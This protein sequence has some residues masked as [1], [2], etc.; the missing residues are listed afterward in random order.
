MIWALKKIQEDNRKF[1][2]YGRLL[3][4][5]F[6]QGVLLTALKNSGVV[7]DVHLGTMIGK[8]INGFTLRSMGIVKNVD[9]LEYDLK[10]S[11]IVPDLMVDFPPISIED[12][13]E[14]LAAYVTTHYEKT[15]EII[16]L[17]SIPETQVGVP[18]RVASKKRKSKKAFLDYS[19]STSLIIIQKI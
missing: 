12:N 18:L 5:I 17:S 3:S 19:G 15:G 8:Y 9:K 4:K 6:Y 14:V 13:A 1:I 11:M 2:P 16:N 7:F 10:E